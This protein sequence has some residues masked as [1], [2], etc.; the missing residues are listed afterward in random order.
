MDG[1]VEHL[2]QSG[3]RADLQLR[4]RRPAKLGQQRVELPEPG[5]VLVDLLERLKAGSVDRKARCND[6]AVAW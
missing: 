6:S 5:P 4:R 1:I 3:E 2:R